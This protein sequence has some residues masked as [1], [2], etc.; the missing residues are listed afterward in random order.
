MLHDARLSRLAHSS[1]RTAV[2]CKSG[3]ECHARVGVSTSACAS[4]RACVRACA[5]VFVHLCMC[6]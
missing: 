6:A 4:V 3:H 1:A 2:P 5:L